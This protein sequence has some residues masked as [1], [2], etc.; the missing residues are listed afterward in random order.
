VRAERGKENPPTSIS[1]S[2]PKW[3]KVYKGMD[4]VTGEKANHPLPLPGH[5]LCHQLSTSSPPNTKNT[6][7]HPR[8][9][10]NTQEEGEEKDAHDE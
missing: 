1:F 5:L 2:T 8:A 4:H 10:K 6:Q 9:P 7:E 3:K